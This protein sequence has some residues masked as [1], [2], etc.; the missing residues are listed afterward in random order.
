LYNA[1]FQLSFGTTLGLM[2]FAPAL[3]GF[4]VSLRDR[5]MEIAYSVQ[6]P[7]GWTAVK[8][9]LRFRAEEV[10]GTCLVAAV[11]AAPLTAFHFN[12]FNLWGIP[13]T[14]LLI[15]PVF[16]SLVMGLVKI[17]VSL[18][19]PP[20]A[21][22]MATLAAWPVMSMRWCVDWMASWRGNDIPLPS[23][24]IWLMVSFYI[25]LL[26]FLIPVEKRPVKKWLNGLVAA[27]LAM[28]VFLPFVIAPAPQA[29]S[30]EMK[31][32]LLSVGA[33]QCAVMQL[34][35]GKIVLIDA[36][37]QTPDL[38]RRCL[39]PFLKSQG[40]SRIDSIYL[41][42]ANYDH[43][44][45]AADA[46]RVAEV[47]HIFTGPSFALEAKEHLAGHHLLESLS[48]PPLVLT[49]G[50]KIEL[51]SQTMLEVLWP[52][53]DADLRDND[54]S[55]VLKV[56]SQ[57]RTILFT[58]DIQDVAMR[59]LLGHPENVIC[60]VLVAPHHG[61]SEDST[62]RFVA[63]CGAKIILSSNDNT[64]TQKQVNFDRIVADRSLYRTNR[65]GAIMVTFDRGGGIQT[66]TFLKT[67]NSR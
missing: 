51:D 63:A 34:P 52:P 32:T 20:A 6:R 4:F 50:R 18:L 23:P 13:A 31:L 53:A 30:A 39:S 25:L 37:S 12:Q 60:D 67:S 58:G 49:T 22:L 66:K 17:V 55:L 8:R 26:A 40:L 47:K 57:G 5:D 59:G 61:S 15:V 10:L 11:V 24:S 36:G 56:T 16:L 46:A 33:G 14:I 42:H 35:S 21:P 38:W 48:A 27:T 43:F 41:S 54:A 2:L 65:C 3:L 1:G 64:L 19:F 9:H 28:I 62:A 45:G 29:Q 7:R 44:S